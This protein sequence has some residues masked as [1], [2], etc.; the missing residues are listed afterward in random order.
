MSERRVLG[1]LLSFVAALVVV[2]GGV[3]TF[4]LWRNQSP[5]RVLATGAGHLLYQTSTMAVGE[6]R[7]GSEEEATL[8]RY[9]RDG[10]WII[11]AEGKWIRPSA[12]A[13]LVLLPNRSY[14]LT[15]GYWL[16]AVRR[17]DRLVRLRVI[18]R[19]DSHSAQDFPFHGDGIIEPV[20]L[21]GPAQILGYSE[22]GQV[23]RISW[24]PSNA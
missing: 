12:R 19:A 24:S 16:C 20:E 3:Y 14:G 11:E 9:S 13:K 1:Q 7:K 4:V 15:G 6:I 10:G 18:E 8:L 17:D 23:F 21:D 5:E 22:K 2:G